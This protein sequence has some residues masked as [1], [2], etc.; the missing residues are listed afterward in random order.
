MNNPLFYKLISQSL[1]IAEPQ[2]AKTIELL[3]GGA[4]IPFISRYRKE[5]TG[6]LDEVQIGNI[7]EDYDRLC[8]LAKR[9]E[10]ILSTIGEQGKLTDELRQRIDSCWNATELE[11]IYLPYKPRRRT[12]AEI[13]REHGLEP[14]AKIIMSQRND[15][16]ESSAGRFVNAEVPDTESAIKGACDIIAEWVAENERARHTVRR[17]FEQSGVIA[18]KVVKGKEAEGDKYRDYFAWSEPLR[19]CASH[20]ILAVR[21]GEN[22]GILRVSITPD[23]EQTLPRLQRLFVKG[24]GEASRLVTQTVADSYKRLLRP[25]IESEF[26]AS[27]KERADDEAAAVYRD[28]P[29]EARRVPVVIVCIRVEADNRVKSRAFIVDGEQ[30]VEAAVKYVPRRSE[31]YTRSKGLL[32]V[33]ALEEKKVLMVAFKQKQIVAIKQAVKEVDPSAFLIVCDAH[34]VLGDGFREYKQNDL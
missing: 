31:L 12:R 3:D 13:A 22:E 15:R 11:D 7:K 33:G 20:K 16:I 14:L 19:R 32:E 6:S 25:S 23:D 24:D 8:E 29:S 26:A 5:A 4:T 18:A 21:R 30:Q 27:S 17:G 34:E 2:I 28:L 1:G 10:S 9:K